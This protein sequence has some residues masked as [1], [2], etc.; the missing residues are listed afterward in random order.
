MLTRYWFSFDPSD[1]TVRRLRFGFGV[2]VTAFDEA[3]AV[4]LVRKVTGR[5]RLPTI[6]NMEPNVRYDDL[7]ANHVQKN[8]GNMA[9]RGVWYPNYNQ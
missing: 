2:G 4:A 9:V 1:E 6:K 3:D 7:E 5:D 8:L